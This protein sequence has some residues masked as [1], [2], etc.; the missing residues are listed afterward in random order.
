MAFPTGINNEYNF[1]GTASTALPANFGGYDH[2]ARSLS[3]NDI[4]GNT[5]SLPATLVN[6]GTYTYAFDGVPTS[7][8]AGVAN[9]PFNA[10]KAHAVVMVI[11]VNTGEIL[12]AE[13]ASIMTVTSTEEISD[14][15]IGLTVFPNPTTN[16]ADV[17]F[18][19]KNANNVKMEVYNAMGALVAS[20]NA[21]TL[22]KGNHK[23]AFNGADLN[24]GL[25][26]VN[27]TIGN[28]TVTKKITLTK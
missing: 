11:N 12:N 14:A 1:Y 6:T 27:L 21:G 19:L 28:Y 3:N 10:D 13:K 15:K 18:K 22:A 2:V 26:F 25:Y 9:S 23:M 4:L 7:S 17:S 16:F 5:G 24:A 20:E 8:L